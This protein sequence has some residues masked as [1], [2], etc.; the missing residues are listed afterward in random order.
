MA[1]PTIES[2]LAVVILAAGC[3]SRL[4]QPK[5]LVEVQGCTLI[6]RQCELALTLTEDVF[7]V[8]GYHAEKVKKVINHLPV[9]VITNINWQQGM[10]S[11]IAAGVNALPSTVKGAMLLLVDQ[12]Q[13]TAA[14]LALT[15][16]TWH[17][18]SNNIICARG[19]SGAL[20]PP[21]IFP[22]DYFKQL[23]HIPPDSGAKA[24]VNQH[25]DNV[26]SVSSE[27]AFA[28]LDTPEHLQQC[29]RYFQ[30]M[31]SDLA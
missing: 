7:V 24:I 19:K 9:K 11:S 26:I 21:I 17:Q 16:Q 8:V 29:L 1:Y 5:Q 23:K 22:C 30:T 28:D 10:G 31:N 3:S 20:S 2:T 4:G 27:A 15:K 13:L 6:E 25:G 18:S 14:D 12:W